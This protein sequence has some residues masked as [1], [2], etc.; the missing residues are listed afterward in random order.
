MNLVMSPACEIFKGMESFYRAILAI[1]LLTPIAAT[2]EPFIHGY[3]GKRSYVAGE[4][5]T[6]HLSTD[7]AKVDVEIAILSSVGR[8]VE[9]S[10]IVF[11]TD[12]IM[13]CYNV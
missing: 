1:I 3:P 6:F 4:E 11:N 13:L 7:T 5:V 12:F 2:A 9:R 8:W 10:F